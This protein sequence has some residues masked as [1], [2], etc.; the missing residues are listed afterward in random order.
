MAI[1]E[2]RLALLCFCIFIYHS[3][4]LF[5]HLTASKQKLNKS[6]FMRITTVIQT[7]GRIFR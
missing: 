2:A 5:G 1:I 7:G 4:L 6:I 3:I